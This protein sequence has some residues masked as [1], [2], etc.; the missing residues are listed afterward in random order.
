MKTIKTTMN[1][2]AINE[3]LNALIISDTLAY[4]QTPLYKLKKIKNADF[5]CYHPSYHI[6][7]SFPYIIRNII[8]IP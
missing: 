5:N 4:F 8:L 7:M 3:A 2:D 1:N 6:I